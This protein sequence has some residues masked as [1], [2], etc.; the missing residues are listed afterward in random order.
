MKGKRQ[1]SLSNKHIRKIIDTYKQRP[2]SIERYARCVEMSEIE[3]NDFNLNI[4]RYV[5]T[6]KEEEAI[7]LSGHAQGV[8]RYRE[9][10]SRINGE[11]QCVSQGT[12]AIPLTSAQ[13]VIKATLRLMTESLLFLES[14]T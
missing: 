14:P 13:L 12:W 10:A 4:T 5:S 9:A 6:A 3:A 7:D 2:E 1:N 8:G 11:A